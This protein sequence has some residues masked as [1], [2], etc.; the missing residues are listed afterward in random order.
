MKILHFLLCVVNCFQNV[1]SLILATTQL[2]MVYL[3]LSCELLSKRSIFDISNNN[4]I[5][6]NDTKAVVNCF[7]NV[8]SLILATTHFTRVI[9]A[10]SCELLSKRSIFDI[11]NNTKP[12]YNHYA[13]VVNCFQNVVSLILATTTQGVVLIYWRCELLSKRSIFDISNNF[14]SFL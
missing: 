8:V 10:C 5:E 4:H 3:I 14:L 12:R 13:A 11:S 6:N 1:V 9:H 2:I 7:Q